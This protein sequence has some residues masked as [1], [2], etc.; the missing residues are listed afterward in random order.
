M[1]NG[2]PTGIWDVSNGINNRGLITLLNQLKS[3][4][5][6]WVV[7]EDLTESDSYTAEWTSSSNSYYSGNQKYTINYNGYKIDID[8]NDNLVVLCYDENTAKEIAE[9]LNK[10]MKY[11]EDMR[12]V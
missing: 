9:L 4:T 6:N 8:C 1:E 5:S 11:E 3:D 10:D 2:L 12:G 7:V